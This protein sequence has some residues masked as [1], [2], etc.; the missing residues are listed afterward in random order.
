MIEVA[1][2]ANWLNKL[3]RASTGH[4]ADHIRAVS[5]GTRIAMMIRNSGKGDPLMRVTITPGGV[6]EVPTRRIQNGSGSHGS[7]VLMDGFPQGLTILMR[8][9]NMIGSVARWRA[10]WLRTV[11]LHFII[12][13]VRERFIDARNL[14]TLRDVIGIIHIALG[15]IDSHGPEFT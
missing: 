5:L 7:A 1:R 9:P 13:F 15:A 4:A 6:G 14:R 11:T 10:R 8:I 2:I 3:H 12:A